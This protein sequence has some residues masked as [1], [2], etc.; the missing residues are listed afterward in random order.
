MSLLSGTEREYCS[1][2]DYTLVF[3]NCVVLHESLMPARC[4]FWL[5]IEMMPGGRNPVRELETVFFF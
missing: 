4:R 3:I 1:Y 5:P 2:T